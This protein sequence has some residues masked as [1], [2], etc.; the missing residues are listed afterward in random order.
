ME[1]CRVTKKLSFFEKTRKSRHSAT[2][3]SRGI[4]DPVV[5]AIDTVRIERVLS[6]HRL[7]VARTLPPGMNAPQ[8]GG[9]QRLV[10]P[11]LSANLNWWFAPDMLPEM[12]ES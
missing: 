3:N 4:P 2:K 11:T 12:P 10:R 6:G 1:Q 9:E 5:T 8:A 7:P